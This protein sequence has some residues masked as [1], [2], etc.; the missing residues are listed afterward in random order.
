[1]AEPAKLP[2]PPD[3]PPRAAGGI[4]APRARAN[5]GA[6]Y[7]NGLNLQQRLAVATLDAHAVQC[8]GHSRY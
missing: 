7:L 3:A 8:N 5:A 1:M 2:P 6:P 4:A